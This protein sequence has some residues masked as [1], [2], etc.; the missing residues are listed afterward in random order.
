MKVLVI[1]D[2]HITATPPEGCRPVYIDDIFNMLE[3]CKQIVKDKSV[4]ETIFTGDIFHRTTLPYR[5]LYRLTDILNGWTGSKMGIVGNHDLGPEGIAGIADTPLGT[6]FQHET[7]SWL[8][9]DT[10]KEYFDH[11][12]EGKTEIVTVQWS[13][14]NWFD[15]IDDDPRNFGLKRYEWNECDCCIKEVD[16]A[17]KV[18]HGSL[19]RPGKKYP[20]GFKLVT[21]DQ[22][23]TDGMDLC[24]FGHI[25][26]DQGIRTVNDCV[27]AGLGSIGRVART[28]YNLRKPRVLIVNLTTEEMTFET[29]PLESAISPEELYYAKSAPGAVLTAPMARFARDM[30]QSLALEDVSLEEALAEVSGK[31]V[32]KE[33][34]KVVKTH[35]EKAGY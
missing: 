32:D 15:D 11:P 25:H 26:N 5:Y 18:A 35:L 6:L 9:E 33:V 7:I 23:P 12:E 34:I 8:K 20:E 10:E 31:G 27:F 3:E 24:L 22:V 30:E 29:I 16:W 13:P 1:N 21:Y 28:D 14:A 4:S 2:L 17:I 19:M